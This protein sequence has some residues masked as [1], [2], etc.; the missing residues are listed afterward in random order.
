MCLTCGCNDAHKKMGDNVTYEDIR[1]VAVEN[2]RT[3]DET[4]RILAE[5][6]ATDRAQHVEE[7]ERA[8]ETG[9]A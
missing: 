6:A 4:L 8:W 3:V 7:Y 1:D 2:G 5:T 9:Q